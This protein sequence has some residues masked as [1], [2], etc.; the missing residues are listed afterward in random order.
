MNIRTA[1]VIAAAF[2][3]LGLFTSL[4][5]GNSSLIP[6]LQLTADG[7]SDGPSDFLAQDEQPDEDPPSDDGDM[8]EDPSDDGSEE[9]SDEEESD[10]DESEDAV[11]AI[12]SGMAD[13]FTQAQGLSE[14][15]QA[16]QDALFGYSDY[17]VNYDTTK[18]R[19][20]L[21]EP[22]LIDLGITYAGEGSQVYRE[23]QLLLQL[24]LLDTLANRYQDVEDEW[25]ADPDE[26]FAPDDPDRTLNYYQPRWNPFQIPNSI[27]DELKPELEGGGLSGAVDPE[28]LSQ[29]FWAQYEAN[30]RFIPLRIVGVMETG[31]YSGCMYMIGNSRTYWIEEGDRDC[32]WQPGRP[33]FS[34]TA[35]YVSQ[36]YVVLVLRGAYDYRCRYSATGSVVRTFHVSR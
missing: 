34:V 32:M 8:N 17:E 20:E 13:I 1:I 26:D 29:L 4:G 16:I 14:N 12:D 25:A 28:L 24:N 22:E 5:T 19:L 30:L 2:L 9:E 35:S 18:T 23:T 15:E 11:D 27:P 6:T 31:P 7:I 21:T 33:P 3:L 10:E 36:D